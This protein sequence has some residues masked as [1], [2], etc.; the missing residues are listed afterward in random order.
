M[1]QYFAIKAK[2]PD[3][4][5]LFRVGDFYETF[6]EDAKTASAVLGIT[7][8]SR[9]NGGDQ[10]PLAGVPF[11]SLPLYLPRLVRAGYRV[12]ICE[13]LEKPDKTK[14][15]LKRGVTEVITPGVT[16]DD[17]LLDHRKNNYL[18][19]I[20]FGKKD[21]FG[22]A[23][24][25]VSTG[26]FLVCEGSKLYIEKLLQSFQPSEILFSRSKKKEFEKLYGNKFYTYPIE[27]W[28]FMP[29]YTHEK[30]IEQFQ[31]V[32]LK[33]FGIDELDLAQIASG[34]I[35]HYLATTE[36]TN[37]KHI[38]SISRV[39]PDNYVWLDRF[40][41]RNL[42]LLHSNHETGVPLLEILDKTISPMGARL[43]KKWVVLPL[44]ERLAIEAR[45]DVV[46]YFLSHPDFSELISKHVRLIGDIERLISK[47][48]LG[49]V[50]PREVVQ[51]KRALTAM[52]PLK[53]AMEKADNPHLNKMAERINLC[54]VMRDQ[55][56]REI[57]DGPTC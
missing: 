31:V 7:L 14:K 35:L 37:L 21:Q 33:G 32:S 20:Q 55:I 38:T 44:K 13:Q 45:H 46:E 56:E 49:K 2:H 10:T 17:K 52:V 22:I 11:H 8:T 5:L 53:E 26:E 28:V 23:F 40:T 16:I 43:M 1:Q 54:A 36:N 30:L 3:A 27:E 15:I 48:P 29:D 25:D 12:A 19:A 51:L 42:E 4:I 39:Q 47:V 57:V 24:L 6:G 41:I 18:A 50:N 9:N 34:A